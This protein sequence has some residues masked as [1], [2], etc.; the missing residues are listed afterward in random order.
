MLTQLPTVPPQDTIV[1]KM[2]VKH[3]DISTPATTYSTRLVGLPKNYVVCGTAVR[4]ITAFGGPGLSSLTVS[5]AAFVP[6]TIL[7]DLLYYGSSIELTQT[8]TP[9]AFSLSG[10]PNNNLSLGASQTFAPATAL[11]FNGPHDVAAYFTATGANLSTLTGGVVEFTV[12]IR[13]F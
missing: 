3:T 10:P 13:P 9:Q 1:Y 8:V 5:L 11:Y 12:Q 4:L 2:T 6:N 7:N